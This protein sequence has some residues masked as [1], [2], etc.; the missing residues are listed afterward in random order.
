M[1]V[2]WLLDMRPTAF[3]GTPSYALHLAEVAAG[4]NV[5]PRDFGLRVM[6]FSGEPGAGIPATK[7]RIEEAFGAACIDSGSMAEM[8]PWMTNAE[9]EFRRGMHL[10]QDIVYC[11][12]CDPRTFE[13]VAFGGEG[14]PVYT[15]LERTSQPM[16]RLASGDLTRWVDDPCECGRTYPR[17]PRGIYG[18]LDD[19]C[20]IRGANIYPSAIEELLREIAGFGGEFQMVIS[21]ERAMDELVVRVEY[22]QDVA[23]TT[24]TAPDTLDALKQRIAAHLRSAIGSGRSSGSRRP[25]R[26]PG[27]SSRPG[28]SWTTAAY[29]RKV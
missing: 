21:R 20:I 17:L 24:G 9:C 3:Y 27:R 2:R 6:V 5:D 25:G 13:P 18:R 10:W 23:R 29:M 19:M 12:V 11:E 1:A 8:T 14:T 15:H 16:I 28:G 26:C 22:S 7:R 4:E